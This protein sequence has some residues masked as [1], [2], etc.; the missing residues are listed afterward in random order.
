MGCS[1]TACSSQRAGQFGRL[2]ADKD[3][4]KGRMGLPLRAAYIPMLILAFW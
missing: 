1:G 3:M 4:L 2:N